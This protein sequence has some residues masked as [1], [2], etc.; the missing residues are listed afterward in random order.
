MVLHF[1]YNR[2]TFENS[3]R[4][5]SKNKTYKSRTCGNRK[6]TELINQEE[7]VKKIAI[8]SCPNIY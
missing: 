5:T 6:K 1:H 4:Q 7:K 8:Y 3:Q 2:V